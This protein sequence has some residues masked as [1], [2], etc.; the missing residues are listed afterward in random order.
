MSDLYNILCP[1]NIVWINKK[2]F[3]NISIHSLNRAIKNNRHLNK[4]EYHFNLL[5]RLSNK[6]SNSKNCDVAWRPV[7]KN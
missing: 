5:P 3:G 1:T 2:K 6:V 7:D 4:S